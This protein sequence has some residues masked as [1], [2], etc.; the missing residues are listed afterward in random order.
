ML[1]ILTKPDIFA[2]QFGRFIVDNYNDPK[3][4]QYSIDDLLEIF[5]KKSSKIIEDHLESFTK[6]AV[7]DST[8]NEF[9]AFTKATHFNFEDAYLKGAKLVSDKFFKSSMTI[10]DMQ[11]IVD[12]YA[13]ADDADIS[14]LYI[15]PL[16][17]DFKCDYK[18]IVTNLK[19]FKK[20]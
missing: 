13:D 10:A 5:K 14:K 12:T 7:P 15:E 8:L 18:E 19:K 1:E 3:F 6:R 4:K 2:K 20:S 11:Y 16:L 17:M 9:Y